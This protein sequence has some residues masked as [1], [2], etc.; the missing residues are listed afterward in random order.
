MLFQSFS[1]LF[2]LPNIYGTG[3]FI[4]WKIRYTVIFKTIISF[5]DLLSH[6]RSKHVYASLLLSVN[7]FLLK[8]FP[9]SACEHEVQTGLYI[10]VTS[11]QYIVDN[12]TCKFTDIFNLTNF[13]VTNRNVLSSFYLFS[14]L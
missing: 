9:R 8:T 3:I 14:T 6:L 4:G 5:R 1:F 2:Y 11:R 10:V 13:H 12:L 7:V